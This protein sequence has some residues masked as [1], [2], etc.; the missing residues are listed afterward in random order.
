MEAKELE[1]ISL[2]K[3]ESNIL[4]LLVRR[5][6]DTKKPVPSS[7]FDN[8]YNEKLSSSTIR[9]I[10]FKLEKKGYL[11]KEHISSG[12]VPTD[13]S[14]KYFAE[15]AVN[16]L[17]VIEIKNSIG[18]NVK[19][20]TDIKELARTFAED[21]SKKHRLVAFA[22]APSMLD[23]R[24]E[25]IELHPLSGGRV[26]V[27]CLS[28]SG[29]LYEKVINAKQN[30]SYEKLRYFGDNLTQNYRGWTFREIKVHLHNQI[31]NARRKVTELVADAMTL[32]SPALLEIPMEIDIFISGIEWITEIPEIVRDSYSL[33]VFLETIEKK[34]KLL[35]LID[36]IMG[37][38]RESVIVFGS[39]L[40][41]FINYLPLAIV[42]VL[43]GDPVSGKGVIGMIG[44]K[45][46]KYDEALKNL[47][48]SAFFLGKAS[49]NSTL[50]KGE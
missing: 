43:Y 19:D 41:H 35:G 31:V 27:L 11:K 44:G 48:M 34:E 6:I 39:E 15:T 26:V 25:S 7:Y 45:A 28:T 2:T 4:I 40:N 33:K 50:V 29:R 32:V 16:E 17:S 1:G 22:T 13:L 5:Y 20:N 49:I 12:R 24:L 3:R 38:G 14:Y 36:E 30:Y 21:I 9:S 23:A 10:L 42:S 47:S 37:K 46:I 8:V 18:K